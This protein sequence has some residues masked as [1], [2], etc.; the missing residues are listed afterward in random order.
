MS[1]KRLDAATEPKCFPNEDGSIFPGW[2]C[3]RCRRYQGFQR[4]TCV[5]CGHE[6]CYPSSEGEELPIGVLVP[7]GQGDFRTLGENDIKL[8]TVRAKRNV[9]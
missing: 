3:C 1:C 7:A 2:I 8:S 5:D 4:E 9:P 6:P